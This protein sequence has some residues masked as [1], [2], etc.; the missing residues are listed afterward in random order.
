MNSTIDIEKL[1][2]NTS[3]ISENPFSEAIN[4]ICAEWLQLLLVI[5]KIKQDKES[6]AELRKIES[7]VLNVINDSEIENLVQ[8]NPLFQDYETQY[9]PERNHSKINQWGTLDLF[10]KTLDDGLKYESF[11]SSAVQHKEGI[12]ETP[13]DAFEKKQSARQRDIQL[14]IFPEIFTNEAFD[15][16]NLNK[17]RLFYPHSQLLRAYIYGDELLRAIESLSQFD[18]KAFTDLRNERIDHFLKKI[19]TEQTHFSPNIDVLEAISFR[20]DLVNAFNDEILFESISKINKLVLAI[21]NSLYLNILGVKNIESIPFHI[22]RQIEV[23]ELKGGTLQTQLPMS[24]FVEVLNSENQAPLL[25]YLFELMFQQAEEKLEASTRNRLTHWIASRNSKH[26]DLPQPVISA[27]W[28]YQ[29]W[30]RSLNYTLFNKRNSFKL[31]K[32]SILRGIRFSIWFDKHNRKKKT[33]ISEGTELFVNDFTDKYGT[34]LTIKQ[35]YEKVKRFASQKLTEWVFCQV[36]ERLHRTRDTLPA[37]L[38]PLNKTLDENI[39]SFKEQVISEL[40]WAIDKSTELEDLID[41]YNKIQLLHDK[42]KKEKVIEQETARQIIGK[43]PL[44]NEVHSNLLSLIN[45]EPIEVYKLKKILSCQ[46]NV[47]D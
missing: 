31:S 39:I 40:P 27:L 29:H 44:K 41:L 22:Q 47:F 17:V 20:Q 10:F 16:P 7:V 19:S 18:K 33:K 46:I 8:I 24:Y 6:I 43:E 45:E 2:S 13:R 30:S 3:I 36:K 28:N 14:D 23:K 34:A 37:L 1:L 25:K 26:S 11:L 15:W 42:N 5:E 32:N 4:C 21:P 35:S 38:P 9:M 12:K